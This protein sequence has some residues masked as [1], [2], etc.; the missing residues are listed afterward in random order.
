MMTDFLARYGIVGVITAWAVLSA[1]L[2][3]LLSVKSAEE[4]VAWG[5][6]N[7]KLHFVVQTMRTLGVDPVTF[8]THLVDL[9]KTKADEPED[10]S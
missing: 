5:D 4:W 6:Q 8:L 2:N 1:V 3:L 10:K 9:V 7:P